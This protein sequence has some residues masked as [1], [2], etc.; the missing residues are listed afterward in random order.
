MDELDLLRYYHNDS[1]TDVVMIYMGELARDAEQ[2]IREV[3]E[4][5]SGT[6]VADVIITLEQTDQSAD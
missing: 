3:R 4:M 5:T 1:N 6:T 2:F